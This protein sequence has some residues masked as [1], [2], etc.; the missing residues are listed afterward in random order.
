MKI[1][2]SIGCRDMSVPEQRR[3]ERIVDRKRVVVVRPETIQ[4]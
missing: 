2:A 1:F 3:F 4:R